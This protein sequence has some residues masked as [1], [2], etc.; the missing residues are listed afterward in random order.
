MNIYILKTNNNLDTEPI[1]FFAN[2][3]KEAEDLCRLNYPK[4]P[5]QEIRLLSSRVLFNVHSLDKLGRSNA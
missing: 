3:Y 2:N 1:L 5:Q 4:A